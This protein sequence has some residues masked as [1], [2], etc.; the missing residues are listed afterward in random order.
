MSRSQQ[1]VAALLAFAALFALVATV[2]GAGRDDD[3]PARE[4]YDTP[5]GQKRDDPDALALCDRVAAMLDSPELDSVEGRVTLALEVEDIAAGARGT[6]LGPA[7]QEF[8]YA[9]DAALADDPDASAR[10]A[11]AAGALR[12]SCTAMG[13]TP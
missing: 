1:V 8:R 11:S 9:F 6:P 3:A 2:T 5:K 13:W 7:T 12:R 10:M 4:A